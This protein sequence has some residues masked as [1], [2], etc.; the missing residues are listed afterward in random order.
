MPQKPSGGC[1]CAVTSGKQ[2]G[3]TL[4]HNNNYDR[5]SSNRNN[6]RNHHNNDENS[7][8]GEIDSKL[9]CSLWAQ[10]RTATIEMQCLLS[11]Q[12]KQNL[13][14]EV[15]TTMA[16]FLHSG[17]QQRECPFWPDIERM[18]NLQAARL[19]ALRKS[20]MNSM[21]KGSACSCPASRR[22]MHRYCLMHVHFIHDMYNVP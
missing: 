20:T 9:S 2:S 21:K 15:P 5:N 4:Q 7:R 11:I 19:S 17:N 3:A 18:F 8:V 13:L 12:F 22:R 6:S 1:G 14:L 10:C 16:R